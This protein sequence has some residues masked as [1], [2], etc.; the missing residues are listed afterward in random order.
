MFIKQV[1][2]FM[3]NEDAAQKFPH[4]AEL[5][6][7]STAASIT[8]REQHVMRLIAAGLSNR[9][10]AVQLSLAE[11]TVKTHLKNIYHKLG[12]NSRTRAIAQAQR[13]KL[14]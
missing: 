9:E 3:E 12:V 7:L 14:V 6:T 10:I 5:T 8:A 1:L 4:K 11:S 2:R 13:L